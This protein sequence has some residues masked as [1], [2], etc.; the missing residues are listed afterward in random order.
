MGYYKEALFCCLDDF[1]KLYEEWE[2]HHLIPK[3]GQ[4]N[5]P[6]KMRFSELLFIIIFYHT[7]HFRCFKIFYLYGIFRHH[8]FLFRDVISY[9][10]YVS[11]M[12]R[13]LLHH[14]RGEKTGIYIAE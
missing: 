9:G 3:T 12:P 7:S 6:G 13:L 10:R 8:R 5:R 2:K 11:L 1:C 14:L 4:R